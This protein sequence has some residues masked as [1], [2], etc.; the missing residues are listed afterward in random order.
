MRLHRLTLRNVRGV[1]ER[2]VELSPGPPDSGAGGD[3]GSGDS[4][5]DSGSG[6][7]RGDTRGDTSGD[8]GVVIVEGLNEAGKSTLGD[9]LDVLLTYKDSSKHADVR[10]LQSTGRDEPPEIEAEL[11]VG[12]HRFTYAKR[13]LK[14]TGTT[15]SITAPRGDQLDGDA[16]HERVEGLL[17]DHLDVALWSSLRL[18]QAEG[19][20]QAAPGDA[21]GLAT[22]LSAVSDASAIGDRELSILEQV[23]DTYERYFTAK[24]GTP[25]PLLRD[26]DAKV[27]QLNEEL[28]RIDERRERLAADVDRAD[29]LSRALPDLRTQVAEALT[30]AEEHAARRAEVTALAQEVD[31]RRGVEAQA[32][33]ALEQLT[34]RRARRTALVE[35]LAEVERAQ[36]ERATALA[37]AEAA[38]DQARERLAE[39]RVALEAAQHRQHAARH[40]RERAQHD[41]DHLAQ[42]ERAAALR[43]R[44]ERAAAALERRREAEATCTE[45]RVDEGLLGELRQAQS[46]VT[47]T[48]A[49]LDAASPRVRFTAARDVRLVVDGAPIDVAEGEE[50]SWTV[51]DALTLDIADLGEVDVR[52]GAGSEDASEAHRLATERLQAA[53]DRGGVADLLAAEHALRRRQDAERTIGE[54]ERERETALD[55]QGADELEEELD[56]LERAA[57]RYLAGRDGDTPPPDSIPAAR[58][59]LDAATAEERRADDAVADPTAEVETARVALE[60]E[61]ADVIELTTRSTEAAARLTAIGSELAD[62]RAGDTDDELDR[63]VAA[64]ETARSAAHAEVAAAESALV[65][66][67]PDAVTELADNAAAVAADARER[68]HATEQDLRDTRVRITAL[69]GDG[70][71]EQREQ[72]ATELAHAR[73]EQQGLHRRA[74]AARLLRDTLERHRGQARDRYA[75]PL[76][77][78]LVAYGRMLHGP[79]FDVEFDDDLR[80]SRRHLDGLW[81]DVRQLS[82]GAREQLA[83]LGRLACATLLGDQ[84]GVLLFDDALGNTDP[85]RLERIGAVLRTAGQH[86]QVIVLT[87]YPDRYRHVGGARRVRL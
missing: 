24:A 13:Y 60:R 34:E 65:D 41:L 33:T 4:G 58:A 29:R 30:R 22:A 76:R 81:L 86:T 20:A 16:A 77:E 19:L 45:L 47:R 23:Q 28:D 2:T 43:T 73:T 1:E 44:V 25:K 53:L 46:E 17:A 15:L 11:Q 6:E 71:W 59:V 87:S 35:E 42:Q 82:V 38:Q 69:G 8:T 21:R 61:R 5:G 52:A 72:L 51:R 75:A 3:G 31:R 26:A 66:A 62:A 18:R 14:R 10:S 36:R 67:D 63:E 74:S 57:D 70:L 40:A 83:L 55:G 32:T 56:R 39:A 12:E 79:G 85:D 54:A 9:A 78:Q 48:E 7:P 27:A 64:A 50:A 84:G 37:A 68:L 49:A 80:V